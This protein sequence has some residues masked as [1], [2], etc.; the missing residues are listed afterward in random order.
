MDRDVNYLLVVFIAF[1]PPAGFVRTLRCRR[2]AP[3]SATTLA[4]ASPV[5]ANQLICQHGGK[6]DRRKGYLKNKK[7]LNIQIN[8]IYG[9]FIELFVKNTAFVC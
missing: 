3:G 5:C 6:Y 2:L 4:D 7:I 1:C 8:M 9:S